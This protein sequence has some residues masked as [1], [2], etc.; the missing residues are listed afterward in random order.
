[1]K[2]IVWA[3]FV[4]FAAVSL[5]GCALPEKPR[6]S[7][8]PSKSPSSQSSP[9]YIQG[10]PVGSEQSK[11]PD[12]DDQHQ[13]VAEGSVEVTLPT[14]VYINDRIF[15]YGRKLDRWKELDTQSVTRNLKDDEAAQMVSCFRSLQ[16]V[17]NGYSNL[18]TKILQ[19]E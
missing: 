2:K 1:M 5:G 9:V 12:I 16:N 3:A 4:A 11:H 18:R 15:E 13:G 8:P 7:T 14:T 17:L 10:G 19:T 6:V